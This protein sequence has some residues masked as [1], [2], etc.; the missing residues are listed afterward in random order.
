MNLYHTFLLIAEKIT[1]ASRML[2]I[3]LN[4]RSGNCHFDLLIVICRRGDPADCFIA[5]SKLSTQ[6]VNILLFWNNGEQD[7]SLTIRLLLLVLSTFLAVS[8]SFG[9]LG[10][11]CAL[12][13]LWTHFSE[14][15]NNAYKQWNDG[16][17][18]RL[19]HLKSHR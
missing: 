18:L 14:L 16:R 6:P 1:Q 2:I 15:Y 10:L 8:P 4:G 5:T 17:A 12:N 13:D 11:V 7:Y 9:F 3:L 19:T